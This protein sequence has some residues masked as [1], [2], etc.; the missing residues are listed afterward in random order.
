MK[1]ALELE[2]CDMIISEYSMANFSVMEALDIYRLHGADIPFLV[3]SG[4]IG[5]VKAVQCIKAG[6]H[7]F[8]L[9][10]NMTRFITVVDRE[11][12]QAFNRRELVKVSSALVDIEEKYRSYVENAPDVVFLADRSGRYIEVNE[13]G[14]RITGYSRE[15]LLGMSILDMITGES[16][17]HAK[18]QFSKLLESGSINADFAVTHKDGSTKWFAVDAIQLSETRFLGFTRDI[19][20]RKQANME[21]LQAREE[22]QQLNQ[23]LMDAR[24]NE[25]ASVAMEIH[26]ELGQ[27]LTAMKID[28]TWVV[29]HIHETDKAADKL[30]RIIDMTNDTIKRVQRI[31]SELRPGLLDDLGLAT[32]IEWYCGEYEERTGIK[33]ELS[34]ADVD[35]GDKRINLAMFRIFQEALTNVIRHA[36][37]KTVRVMLQYAKHAITMIIE[38]DGVGITHAKIASGKSLG[39]IGMRERAR[40]INGTIEFL[41]RSKSGTRIVTVIPMPEVETT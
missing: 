39:L 33:C 4:A 24:E 32:A 20:D 8:M 10:A 27:A 14:S 22:L 16:Y 34:L 18:E 2:P 11:L 3:V 35:D 5:E 15:E 28:M 13:A 31:S 26:D 41:N 9:K 25:R 12:K 6:A 23:Y 17:H 21:V 30:S 40:Q 38:D 7:D 1:E 37:A 19:T 29:E 36:C